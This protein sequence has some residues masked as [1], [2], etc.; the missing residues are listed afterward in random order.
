M[1]PNVFAEADASYDEAQFVLYGVPFDGTSSFRAGSRWAPDEMRKQSYNFETYLPEF[2]VD[3]C[4]VPVH[5]MG[6]VDTYA[7]VDKTLEEVYLLTKGIVNAGK[8]TIMMGGEHSLTY[9]SVKAFNG[10]V[11]GGRHIGVVVMDA[12]LDLR[13]EYRGI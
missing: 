6:N 11:G 12:H 2:D 10:K 9:P 5:D 8:I 7:D 13:P 3:L 4:H 1:S